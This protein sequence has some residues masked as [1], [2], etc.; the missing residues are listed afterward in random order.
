MNFSPSRHHR[1][2]SMAEESA[3]SKFM[4]ELEVIQEIVENLLEELKLLL[5]NDLVGIM[6]SHMKKLEIRIGNH[7][8]VRIIG[9][10]DMAGIG[11]TILTHEVLKKISRELDASAF[12]DNYYSCCAKEIGTGPP[13]IGGPRVQ[14][15]SGRNLGAIWKMG[16]LK[17]E[18]EWNDTVLAWVWSPTCGGQEWKR[19]SAVVLSYAELVYACRLAGLDREAMLGLQAG[20]C[21][22]GPCG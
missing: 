13:E 11:K 9:M 3:T 18:E 12:V 15:R 19:K 17:V 16:Q 21:G 5:S 8:P 6:D 4:N 1:T 2:S 10:W 22:A 20:P 14:F 7:G